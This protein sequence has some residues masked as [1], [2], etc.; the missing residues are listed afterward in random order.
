MFTF[1]WHSFLKLFKFY[2]KS[3][4]N[5][6]A[7]SRRSH[8]PSACSSNPWLMLAMRRRPSDQSG[9]SSTR[10]LWQWPLQWLFVWAF[11]LGQR[12]AIAS[13]VAML[14]LCRGSRLWILIPPSAPRV[15]TWFRQWRRIKLWLMTLWWRP[16]WK[17]VRRFSITG[18]STTSASWI[19]FK[20]SERSK[21]SVKDKRRGL[22]EMQNVPS[23]SWRHLSQWWAWV[24]TSM[25]SFV[26][27]LHLGMVNLS[28]LARWTVP[29]WVLGWE[30]QLPSWPWQLPIVPW[31][32]TW[33]PFAP[34]ASLVWCQ[35]WERLRLERLW[36]QPLVPQLLLHW[37]PPRS[38][39]WEI[40]PS[41]ADVCWLE[42]AQLATVS[43]VVLMWGWWPPTL[44]TWGLPSTRPWMWTNAR[45]AHTAHPWTFWRASQSLFARW[46]LAVLWPTSVRLLPSSIS[47]WFTARTEPAPKRSKKQTSWTWTAGFTVYGFRPYC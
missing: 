44:P 47:S 11:L 35:P 21:A 24:M 6:L 28:W 16:W 32:S 36:A 34:L 7:A 45:Q 8:H 2:C 29:S 40:R 14:L 17:Q 26:L 3:L 20:P 30:T 1:V 19:P 12:A 31:A 9:S 4:A 5:T 27:A 10:W 23:T 22:L 15:T 33:M 43:S 13:T 41:E 37:P 39:F 25:P 42:K 38:V 18:R 46:T